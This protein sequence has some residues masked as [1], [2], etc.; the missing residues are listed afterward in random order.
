METIDPSDVESLKELIGT[1][2]SRPR[3]SVE[4]KDQKF[5]KYFKAVFSR[6]SEHSTTYGEE[7]G[8]PGMAPYSTDEKVFKAGV[9]SIDNNLGEQL[10]IVAEGVEHY[11]QNGE[12]PPPYYAWRIAVILRKSKLLT[13][14]LE[15]LEAFNA[16]FFDGIGQRYGQ[17][18]ERI[19]RVRNL[20]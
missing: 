16:K 19:A 10:R 1:L 15:F 12:Y 2:N 13:L 18:G 4:E 5:E 11:F 9:K 8:G 6:M 20:I 7:S 14:E 3:L 17:I